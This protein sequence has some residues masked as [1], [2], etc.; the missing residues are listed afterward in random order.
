[1]DRKQTDYRQDTKIAKKDY[2]GFVAVLGVLGVL[3][4]NLFAFG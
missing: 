2:P 3:A 4:V 1:L